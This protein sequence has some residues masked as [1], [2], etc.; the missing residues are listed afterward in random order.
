[1]M[2]L[3]NF[4]MAIAERAGRARTR[5]RAAGWCM[6]KDLSFDLQP[7]RINIESAMRAAAFICT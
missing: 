1:M 6:T 3:D 5:F 2:K 7:G 4:G